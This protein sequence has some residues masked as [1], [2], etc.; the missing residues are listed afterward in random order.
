[1]CWENHRAT[2]NMFVTITQHHLRSAAALMGMQKVGHHLLLPV[3]LPPS[4][5]RMPPLL[6]CL[7]LP[8]T[9]GSAVHRK[10]EWEFNFQARPVIPLFCISFC[11]LAL[12]SFS[13]RCCSFFCPSHHLQHN[14]SFSLHIYKQLRW[15]S[16]FAMQTIRHSLLLFPVIK[17]QNLF[18]P[19]LQ[20][21]L[22]ADPSVWCASLCD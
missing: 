20:P 7:L 3:V 13:G 17:L 10:R 2:S 6:Q 5:P 4:R 19:S 21:G 14:K 12:C 15:F 9:P 1:M 16:F 8:L 22:L 18:H 11:T